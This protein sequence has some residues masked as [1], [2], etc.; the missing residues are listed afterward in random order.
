MSDVVEADFLF[1]MGSVMV[2]ELKHKTLFG[3]K[4]SY[5]WR[6]KDQMGINGPFNSIMETTKHWEST[7][8]KPKLPSNVIPVD[9][10]TKKRVKT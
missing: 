8:A 1:S 10:K 7:V 4:S 3:T 6:Y 5:F 9:F 2:Y